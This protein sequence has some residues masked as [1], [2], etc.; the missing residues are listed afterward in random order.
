MRGNA[1][2][3]A[4]GVVMGAAFGSVVNS[5]VKDL[6]TPLIGIPGR[7]SNFSSLTLTINHSQFAFGD[8][9]NNLISFLL[10]AIA[11]YFFVVLPMNTVVNRMRGGEVSK[12]NTKIC[13]QCC[14]EIPKSATRCAHCTQ[15]VE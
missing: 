8:F 15:P 6:L 2:D 14:S 13:P 1:I 4:V 10:T 9:L 7:I 5:L 11:V 12:P 3:L